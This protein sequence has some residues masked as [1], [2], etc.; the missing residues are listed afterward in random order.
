MDFCLS[1]WEIPPKLLVE[2][3]YMSSEALR[4]SG[5]QF[6]PGALSSKMVTVVNHSNSW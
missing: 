1:F 6:I 5:H 3:K 2:A 4:K